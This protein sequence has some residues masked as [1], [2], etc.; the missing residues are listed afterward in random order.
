MLS[1][2]PL[3][4]SEIGKQYVVCSDP[5]DVKCTVLWHHQ[6]GIASASAAGNAVVD[7][8]AASNYVLQDDGRLTPDPAGSERFHWQ[9][10]FCPDFGLETY[11]PTPTLDADPD[12]DTIM[13][14]DP[15]RFQM[16]H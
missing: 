10:C 9:A 3:I 4:T 11:H 6:S 13:F 5:A 7:G 2:V 12:P 16:H 8:V 15:Q 14:R 1:D